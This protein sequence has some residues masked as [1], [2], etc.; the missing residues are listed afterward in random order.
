MK[1]RTKGKRTVDRP[2]MGVI[3]VLKKG[4][5]INIKE[6]CE[7]RDMEKKLD[8]YDLAKGRELIMM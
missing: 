2:R 7:K 4:S 8:T 1:R 5:D 3:D 6:G